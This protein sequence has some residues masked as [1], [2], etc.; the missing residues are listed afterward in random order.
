MEILKVYPET[1]TNDKK[2]LYIL[3]MGKSISLKD[4]KDTP[5]KVVAYAL[6]KDVNK[7]DEEHEVLVIFDGEQTYSTISKTFKDSFFA[8]CKLMG[9]DDFSVKVV[10]GMT[11]SDRPFIDC[12][13]LLK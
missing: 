11:K 4:A 12:D 2:M 10:H 7:K 3:T 6:Y 13:L 1:I 8:I 5:I 9:D